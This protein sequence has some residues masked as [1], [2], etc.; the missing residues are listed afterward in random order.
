[1]MIYAGESLNSKSNYM[2]YWSINGQNLIVYGYKYKNN[3][4]K[5][6]SFPERGAS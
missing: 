5:M 4:P 1:M 2:S 3:K 6:K